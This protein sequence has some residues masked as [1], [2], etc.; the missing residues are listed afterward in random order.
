MPGASPRTLFGTREATT[1]TQRFNNITDTPV[2]LSDFQINCFFTVSITKPH[3]INSTPNVQPS[4][5]ND[6]PM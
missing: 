5:N 2:K 1:R 6:K 3:T 4:L